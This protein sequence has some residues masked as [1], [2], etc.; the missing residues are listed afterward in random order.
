MDRDR[1]EQDIR[2][3]RDAN[4]NMIRVHAH[5]ERPEF[6]ELCDE[7]GILVWQDFPLQ[8]YYAK[9]IEERAV[10]QIRAMVR[11]L[12]HHPSIALWCCHNEPFRVLNM[13][14]FSKISL[15]AIRDFAEF[16][17]M[18][19]FSNWNKNEL[20]AR[21]RA[22]VLEEDG[23]RPVIPHSGVPGLLREG[24]DGHLY[25]GWYM[26]TMRGLSALARVNRRAI[27]FL[28]E[29]GAQAYPIAENFKKIMPAEKVSG[30]DWDLLQ[31]D[32]L[33]QKRQMDKFVPPRSS[34]SIEDYVGVS[35]W[36]QA[37]LI[38]Y[39]NELLR[40][41]KYNPSGGAVHF[42][43]NDAAPGVTWS[44]VDYWRGLKQGFY[45]LRDSFRP[46]LPMA[47][48]PKRW[49]PQA[50]LISLRLFVANDHARAF[51]GAKLAWTFT[52][53]TGA[54]LAGGNL[55][56][57]IDADAVAAPGRARWDSSKAA[58]GG[59]ALLLVLSGPDIEHDI[60]NQYEFELRK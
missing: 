14:Q 58:P 36:Y 53:D 54:E 37:R 31:K 38:Q 19:W 30:I 16:G 29:Y 17:R 32:F 28:T 46:L 35:Q 23:T 51:H 59:Y 10:E 34:A 57:N 41:H 25:F 55:D 18:F 26:G 1:Y 33:L 12:T 42:L 15:K 56:V 60:V 40:R 4:L 47:E 5:V 13:E 2:L 9:E 7:Y 20:D 45:A 50:E 44:V 6:Y 8:W 48:F 52:D 11:L 24:T 22:T 27:R 43:F 39:H 3:M 21:L 49:Y